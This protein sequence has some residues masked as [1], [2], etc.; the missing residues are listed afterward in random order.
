MNELTH[1]LLAAAGTFMKLSQQRLHMY[2]DYML[3]SVDI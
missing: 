1:L 3:A 2:C